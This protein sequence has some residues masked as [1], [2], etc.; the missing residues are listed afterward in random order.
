MD[1]KTYLEIGEKKAGKQIEL[2][3]ILGIRDSYIRNVKTGRCGLP[4]AACYEL[5]EYIGEEVGN[6]IAASNLVTE[7]DE[8]RKKVFEDYLKRSGEHAMRMIIGGL[9]ISI[10]TLVPEMPAS[11]GVQSVKSNNI[12][13]TKSS[14]HV[15]DMEIQEE[16]L[17]PMRPLRQGI[18]TGEPGKPP[19]ADVALL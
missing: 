9:V 16:T 3:R 7:K 8:R 5:A 10:L 12:H 14:I 1:I 17:R 2:A 18:M 4:N 13:Y 19:G 6:V 15:A 11:A